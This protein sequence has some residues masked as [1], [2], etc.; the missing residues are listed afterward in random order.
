[1]HWRAHF[2]LQE[3]HESDNRREHFE[4]K[5][6]STSPK[7]D[8]MEAFEKNFLNTIPNIKLLS[9]KDTFQNKLKKDIT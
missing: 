8:H 1:M 5:S 4:F 6:K 7:C 9:V 3:K 2:F